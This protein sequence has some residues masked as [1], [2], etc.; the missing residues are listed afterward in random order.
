MSNMEFADGKILASV[1]DGVG[2]VVFNQPEKRNAM[3]VNMW[4]GMG[5][6]LD[7][8]AEDS[9]VRCVVL[10]GAGDKAFVSGADISQ[11]EKVR[12]NADAQQEYDRVT[13]AGRLKLSHYA[14]PVIAQIRGF[15]MGGG[16]G[17]AMSTDIRIA[18]DDSQFGIPA[19]KLS[20]AYGFDMVRA[21]VDLVGPA[22]AHMILMTGERFGAKEAERIG[23]VNKVVPVDQLE[24]EVDRLTATLASNAPLSLTTNKQTVKAVLQ[25]AADRDMGRIRAAMAACFDSADYKE[26]RRAFMEKRK[27]AFT[28]S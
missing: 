26:G 10:A 24:A 18:S 13:S 4:E 27:P 9:N 11:F 1:K 17:I 28:G 3:S 21:L 14:K 22:H 19:A 8:F 5:A 16:L 7:L 20:I 25:D 6:A 12:S 23:L 15:C 2:R